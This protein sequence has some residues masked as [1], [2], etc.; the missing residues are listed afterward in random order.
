MPNIHL[1]IESSGSTSLY[2]QEML[3][4]G[5]IV[6]F[7][8]LVVSPVLLVPKSDGTLQP[9][10]YFKRL[11]A[12]TKP[13][14]YSIPLMPIIIK[15]ISGTKIFSKLDLKDA[16]NQVPVKK[17]HQRFTAFKCPKGIFEYKV[18]PFGLRN[19]P[20]VFQR[21]IDQVLGCLIGVC[22][23]AYMDDILVFSCLKEQHTADTA[24][25]SQRSPRLGYTSNSPNASSTRK[26]YLFLGT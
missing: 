17:E 12:V 2:I 16:F 9:C 25:C 3:A 11:N 21:M 26:K 10:V 15:I 14:N 1:K 5:L 23:V 20:A 13:E 8:T 22:C 19:A 24:R 7:K 18:M 4:R 6:P